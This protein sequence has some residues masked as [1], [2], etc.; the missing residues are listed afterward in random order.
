MDDFS[1]DINTAGVLL[2]DGA[3]VTGDIEVVGDDDWFELRLTENSF[4][5]INLSGLSLA[6]TFLYL[7]DST[8][9]LITSDNASGPGL[10]SFLGLN[11]DAGT[12]YVSARDNGDNHAGTYLSLIHI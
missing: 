10:D 12:Y 7:Y 8:G 11:L 3:T 2:T 1:A 4:A 5:Q 9:T 6:N